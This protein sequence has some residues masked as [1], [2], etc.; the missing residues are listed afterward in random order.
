MAVCKGNLSWLPIQE[1]NVRGLNGE[2]DS[3]EGAIRRSLY[4]V[5]RV[6]DI[7]SRGGGQNLLPHIT[8]RKTPKCFCSVSPYQPWNVAM[9]GPIGCISI[10]CII[11]L[12]QWKKKNVNVSLKVS[13]VWLSRAGCLRKICPVKLFPPWEINIGRRRVQKSALSEE[14]DSFAL[15][16]YRPYYATTAVLLITHNNIHL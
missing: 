11:F 8:H 1:I 3:K 15:R 9:W 13:G 6:G 10:G 7:I 2:D 14:G 4:T 12:Y 16:V 5:C